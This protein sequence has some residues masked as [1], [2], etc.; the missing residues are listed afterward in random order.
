M[1][2]GARRVSLV[3]IGW[4]QATVA[5]A[6]IGDGQAVKLYDGHAPAGAPCATTGRP[7][8]GVSYTPALDCAPD[9]QDAPGEQ[10]YDGHTPASRVLQGA[11]GALYLS[12]DTAA[13]TMTPGFIADDDVTALA[14]SGELDGAIPPPFL[15][16]TALARLKAV[17]TSDGT[18]YLR[19]ESA[20]WPR[21]S[22]RAD[23]R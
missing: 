19:Q 21:L 4:L 16:M 6:T 20:V 2:R 5:W 1:L 8:N 17:H 18:L 12:E 22:R 11:D 10:A 23:H 3:G 7:I 9:S 14:S 13:R 15:G